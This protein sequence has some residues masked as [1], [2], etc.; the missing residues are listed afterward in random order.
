MDTPLV[1]I[2]LIVVIIVLAAVAPRWIRRRAEAAARDEDRRQTAAR[3]PRALD[4]L[5][6]TL[7]VH[8]GQSTVRE[9][10]DE[11]ALQDP[12]RFTPLRPGAYGIRFV[13]PDDALV[14]LDDTR[15]GTLLRIERVRE[16]LGAPQ[17]S[18]SWIL[19]RDRVASAARARGIATED[20]DP[21]R[22]RRDDATATW[23]LD[24]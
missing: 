9:I 14:G 18:E 12:H 23:R 20:G 1:F 3:V 13:E 22:H 15:D 10:V 19:L 6:A 16:Y 4:M 8:A 24:T 2:V 7:V 11:V 5:G 21:V 17:T